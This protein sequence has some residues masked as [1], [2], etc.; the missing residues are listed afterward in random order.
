MSTWA[1]LQ[2]SGSREQDRSSAEGCGGQRLGREVGPQQSAGTQIRQEAGTDA[3]ARIWCLIAWEG[4]G[5]LGGSGL[6]DS[7]GGAGL[8]EKWVWTVQGDQ[9]CP[10]ITGMTQ[11]HQ[12]E[13]QL[14]NPLNQLPLGL[15][16]PLGT[17]WPLIYPKEQ[18]PHLQRQAE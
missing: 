14:P 8:T 3:E 11:P 18:E 2:G 13:E 9:T 5:F 4:A 6:I 16:P 10:V 12:V 17:R 15:L 7:A 1:S